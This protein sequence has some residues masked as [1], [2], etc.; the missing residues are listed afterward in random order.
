MSKKHLEQKVRDKAAERDRY[1]SQLFLAEERIQ[2]SEAQ[3]RR[4]DDRNIEL[5]SEIERLR[6][7]ITSWVDADDD[8]EDIDGPYHA[9]WLA[10][11]KAVGR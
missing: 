6:S 5:E 11:R 7:L 1:M 2:T 8:P 4:L 3:W 10:L 9:A